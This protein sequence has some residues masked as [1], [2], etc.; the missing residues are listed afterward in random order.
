MLNQV[1]AYQTRHLNDLCPPAD[2][3]LKSFNTIMRNMKEVH[4]GEMGDS[5]ALVHLSWN[6]STFKRIDDCKFRVVAMIDGEKQR[7]RG[8]FVSIRRLNLRKNS[9]SEDCID[10][11]RFKFGDTKSP[12]Y[13]GQ[14]NASVDDVR[15][16][17]FG[18]GGGIIEVTLKLDRFVPLKNIDNTLDVEL[19][20]TANEDCGHDNLLRCYDDTCISKSLEHDGINNCPPP[21]CM[22]E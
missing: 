21:Y 7:N 19:V 11:I 13:C 20:F 10:Y 18:E 1:F 9:N 3:L 16:I 17:Y 6:S 12:K 4:L 5:A 22:D 14:L 15:K 2:S 8:V